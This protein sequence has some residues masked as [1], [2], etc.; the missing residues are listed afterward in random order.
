[1]RLDVELA[2]T[3]QLQGLGAIVEQA[4]R[5]DFATI[6]AA[7]L[8]LGWTPGWINTSCTSASPWSWPARAAL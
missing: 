6:G 7:G 2:T 5:E 1:V 3:K 4:H 8:A